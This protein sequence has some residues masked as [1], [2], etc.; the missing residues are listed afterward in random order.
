[1]A[2]RC[3]LAIWA[4]APRLAA[5]AGACS[6]TPDVWERPSPSTWYSTAG[7]AGCSTSAHVYALEVGVRHAAERKTA[8][9]KAMC[10]E[11]VCLC[12]ASWG[13]GVAGIR[14]PTAMPNV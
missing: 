1:M 9:F 5:D 10:E 8:M 4:C 12:K 14:R 6:D 3:M 11:V 7:R 2:H 13:V